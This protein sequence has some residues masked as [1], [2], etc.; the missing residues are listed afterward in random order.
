MEK[1]LSLSLKGNELKLVKEIPSCTRCNLTTYKNNEDYHMSA[2]RVDCKNFPLNIIIYVRN[3]A[4]R[5]NE[6][7][8]AEVMVRTQ[9]DPSVAL[10][11]K[12]IIGL[13]QNPSEIS[14][15]T[16]ILLFFPNRIEGK[17]NAKT[18]FSCEI[19]K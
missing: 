14:E 9:L 2:E 13:E 19:V 10:V 7:T 11:I 17:K 18:I 1:I 15:D 3:F 4:H 8:Y 12:G 6:G 5:L 16:K